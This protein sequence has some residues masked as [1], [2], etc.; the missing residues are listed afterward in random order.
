MGVVMA[1]WFDRG[2]SPRRVNHSPTTTNI[3]PMSVYFFAIVWYIDYH[4]DYA[5]AAITTIGTR[6]RDHLLT[7]AQLPWSQKFH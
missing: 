1:P 4:L 7:S 6:H 2:H 3:G 5:R